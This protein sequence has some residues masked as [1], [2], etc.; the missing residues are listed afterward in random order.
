MTEINEIKTTGINLLA[1]AKDGNRNVML[2]GLK[3]DFQDRPQYLRK[4]KSEFEQCHQL[5]HPNILKY[6]E[7]KEVD[8]YGTCIVMEW[9]PARSLTQ[10]IAESHSIE[11]QKNIILQ[12]GDAL[13]FMHH[14]GRVHASLDPT[15]IYITH[16]G[17][18]VRLL[19]FRQ[20]YADRMSEPTYALKFRAPEAKDGTV[21]LDARSDIFSLG[22]ILKE[23]DPGARY[24]HVV[25]GSCAL[26]RNNRFADVDSFLEA[27]EHQRQT[28]RKPNSHAMTTL[29]GKRPGV[30]IAAV[31][32]LGVMIWAITNYN[33]NE[34]KQGTPSAQTTA[35][36]SEKSETNGTD[37][38]TRHNTQAAN[39]EKLTGNLTDRGY[40]GELAFLNE[41][42]PQMHIDIDKIYASGGGKTAIQKKLSRYYKG[43][44]KTLGDKTEEQ[45][46]AYDKAFMDYRVQKEAEQ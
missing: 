8:R 3:P 41:L 9:E 46:A 12:I 4:L 21:T 7:M 10:Y 37:P 44:R 20:T 25:S 14:H 13:R 28:Q 6:L 43:L 42:I 24:E 26:A 27:F 2:V 31:A 29:N 35:T 30:F 15:Y 18:R 11:D 19:N 34:A 1:T 16:Q 33:S 32:L 22:M 5:E 45:F 40:T 39:K 23:F 36:P 38:T 17:D